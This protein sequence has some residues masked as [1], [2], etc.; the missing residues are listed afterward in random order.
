MHSPGGLKLKFHCNTQISVYS[1]E[2]TGKL[3]EQKLHFI[4][5]KVC[6]LQ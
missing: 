1:F 4:I 5:C 2:Q 6:T 3:I